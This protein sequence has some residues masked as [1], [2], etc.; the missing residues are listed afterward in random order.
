MEK[1][2]TQ[3]WA[4]NKKTFTD[5]ALT[6]GRTREVGHSKTMKLWHCVIDL[7]GAKRKL[8]YKVKVLIGMSINKSFF[9]HPL[10]S[11]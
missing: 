11:N 7:L 6:L 3:I 5:R 8:H 1:K 2:I 9:T 10:V 4:K